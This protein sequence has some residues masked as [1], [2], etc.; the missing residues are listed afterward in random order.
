MK[1]L[2]FRILAVLTLAGCSDQK[3]MTPGAFT[4]EYV[5]VLKKTHPAAHVKIQ[6]DLQLKISGASGTELT[7]FLDNCYQEYS[8]NPKNKT[9][10]IE[11]YV[12]A[13]S[14]EP[15]FD[16][17]QIDTSRIVPVIKDRGW[18]DEIKKVVMASVG[19]QWSENVHDSF[20]NELVIVYAEDTEKN[21]HYLSAKD[22]EKLPI[23][24]DELRALAVKN[25][26]AMLG[27]SVQIRG[28]NGKYMLIAGGTFEA[29][30][31]LL[32]NLW[33]EKTFEVD[34]DIVVTV[35]ARDVLLITGSKDKDAIT[36]LRKHAAQVATEAPYRL[37]VDLFVY[38]AG[39]FEKFNDQ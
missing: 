36:T 14:A 27:D 32:D 12:S 11:R 4:T 34:G 7:V 6:A 17:T 10:I 18:L 24:R 16:R 22:M 2:F 13:F 33:D 8:G 31:L 38:R 26:R 25:L 19:G 5:N 29:S 15:N 37:T 1:K 23:K 9:A 30:L 3:I 39:K 21:L 28:G 20:N 35:P